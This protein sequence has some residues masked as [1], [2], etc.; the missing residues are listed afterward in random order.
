MRWQPH[1]PVS[2]IFDMVRVIAMSQHADRRR[3]FSAQLR[4]LGLSPE[5]LPDLVHEAVAPE[6]PSGIRPLGP[7]ARLQAHRD[8]VDAFLASGRGSLLLIQDDA[9]FAG[10]ERGRIP[11]VLLSLSQQRWDLFFGEAPGLTAGRLSVSFLAP[12]GPAGQC[13]V[14]GLSRAAA[15][16]LAVFLRDWPPGDQAGDAFSVEN[17]Y[18]AFRRMFPTFTSLAAT[19]RVVARRSPTS[20]AVAT[21]RSPLMSTFLSLGRRAREIKR[22]RKPGHDPR[23]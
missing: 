21:A 4:R 11:A 20:E 19:P 16:E 6:H 1:N 7:G 12:D 13:Q 3:E 10:A 2:G 14:V 9:V 5:V 17:G 15:I 8:V 23:L 18:Q 22:G